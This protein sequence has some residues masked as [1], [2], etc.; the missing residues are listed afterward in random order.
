M[1]GSS[2]PNVFDSVANATNSFIHVHPDCKKRE[3][4]KAA[5]R[6]QLFLKR[7]SDFFQEFEI[8]FAQLNGTGK[9]NRAAHK[10]TC[11]ACNG[12]CKLSVT[13]KERC[14]YLKDFATEITTK[15]FKF[16]KPLGWVRCAIIKLNLIR[17]IFRMQQTSILV[18][19]ATRK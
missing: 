16:L 13:Y 2:A 5:K 8:P 4:E 3:D 7:L 9:H 15:I 17:F 6:C 1:T 12:N 18:D 11:K 10:L 19:T 14:E